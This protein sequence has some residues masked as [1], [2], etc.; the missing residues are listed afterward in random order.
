MPLS[1]E[2]QAMFEQLASAEPMPPLWEMT[3]EQGREMY[4]AARPVITELPVGQID[5]QII[6]S[7]DSEIPIR[8]YYPDGEGPFGTLLYFHGG[9]WVIGDLDTGDAV[10]RE[11]STLA[12]VVVVSVD[13]RMA[14]EAIYPAAVED[15]YA[16]LEWVGK[17]KVLLKGNDKIGVTGESAGGNLSAAVALK[18]RELNGPVVDFQCLVYPVTDCDLSRQSYIDNGAGYML[19][20]ESMKWFWDTYCPDKK[21]RLEPYASP[22]RE[23]NLESLPKALVVTAEFDPLKDEGEAYAKALES[24]GIDVTYKCYDGMIHDFFSTA[25]AFPSSRTGF[26]ETVEVIK[27]ELS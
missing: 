14:P 2:Y 6:K 17:N 19:E 4:R 15:S 8:I 20:V 7:Y 5:N 1:P 12:N 16:A 13:Y 18:T 22:I 26:L 10:C 25:V 24:S 27:T 3:P 9:G 21:K 11:M 23:K